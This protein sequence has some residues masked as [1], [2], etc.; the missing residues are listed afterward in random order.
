MPRVN[1]NDRTIFRLAVP[2]LGALAAE[3]LVALVDTAFVG[4]LGEESLAALGVVNGLLHLAFFVFIALAYASTPLI[5]AAIGAGDRDRAAVLAG[6]SILIAAALVVTGL[7]V[8]EVA[9]P[10]LVRLMGAATEVEESAVGY[11][12]IRG[13]G[14]PALLGITVGHAVYRGLGDTRTPM[15][16]SLGLSL[17]NVILDP[18]LIFGLGWGLAGAGYASVVAQSSG[19]AAFAY[20]LITAHTGLRIRWIPPRWNDMRVLVSAGSALFVRTLVLVATL[21]VATAS[22]A[23]LGVTEVAA[24]QVAAQIWFFLSLVVDSL[25]IAAQNLVAVHLASDRATAR[26]LSRRML[27]WGVVWGILL[28]VLFWML[29]DMLPGWFTSDRSVVVMAASLMPIVA[30]S[31]PLNSLVFVLDGIMIGAAD[32]RFLALAMTGAGVVTCVLLVSAT[33]IGGIW[34]ALVVLMVARL[35]PLA[36]RYVRVVT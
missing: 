13:L 10:Q 25:A 34:S 19:A 33:S 14:L 5:A 20:L 18:I 2:A 12:R 21:T 16:I 30:L 24:H 15:F 4:R 26:R 9:A 1:D 3:P 29:R 22:A 7:L 31:Q 35:V 28:A 23:R 27:L 36:W 17:I 32:F 11:L 8:I 6:Q